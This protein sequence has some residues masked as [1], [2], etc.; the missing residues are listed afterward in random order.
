MTGSVPTFVEDGV[1]AD[2]VVVEV[3]VDEDVVVDEGGDAEAAD[4]TDRCG[5]EDGAACGESPQP[6]STPT[7]RTTM[8]VRTTPQC[9]VAEAGPVQAGRFRIGSPQARAT[10]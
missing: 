10:K 3:V 1:G 8:D 7:A 9:T 4:L 6:A 5:R 2:V